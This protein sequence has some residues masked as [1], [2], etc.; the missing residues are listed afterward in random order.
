MNLWRCLILPLAWLLSG[1]SPAGAAAEDALAKVPGLPIVRVIR[2]RAVANWGT[3]GKQAEAEFGFDLVRAGYGRV[4]P[5]LSPDPVDLQAAE[6]EANPWGYLRLLNGLTRENVLS[7]RALLIGVEAHR[8]E[9][10]PRPDGTKGWPVYTDRL[11]WRWDAPKELRLAY[12]RWTSRVFRE[13]YAAL[14]GVMPRWDIE[15]RLWLFDAATPG[16]RWETTVPFYANYQTY[17]ARTGHPFRTTS[18]GGSPTVYPGVA[19]D[20]SRVLVWA[21]YSDPRVSFLFVYDDTGN[22]LRTVEAPGYW[23]WPRDGG[24]IRAPTAP[25]FALRAQRRDEAAPGGTLDEWF[26][27]N[28]EGDFLGRF[29]DDAGRPVA[30]EQ[31]T[32]T[33]AYAER[34]EADGTC[35]EF[36]IRLQ[37]PKR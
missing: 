9:Y 7:A 3:L 15:P 17:C 8:R 31:L 13:R 25:L 10:S 26:L 35:T 37:P 4:V 18:W 5:G 20:G 24:V 29:V 22:P 12:P 36:I 11:V 28:G 27:V 21:G 19:H 33:H 30:P 16:P 6:D 34:T 1:P 32:N 23:A 2:G 14:C